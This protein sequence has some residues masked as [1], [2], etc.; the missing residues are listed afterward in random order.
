[1]TNDFPNND[2]LAGQFLAC[3]APG[4]LQLPPEAIECLRQGVARLQAGDPQ[5]AMAPLA[6][7]IQYAPDFSEAHTFLGLANALTSNIYP[8]IDHLE[9]ATQLAPDSFAAQYALAQLHF[10]LRIPQKGYEAAERA[11]SR[12]RTI[13]QRKKLTELLREERTRERNGIARPS[14]NKP[15]SRPTLVLAGTGFLA[16]L[17]AI[18]VHM[19]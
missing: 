13:E 19:H 4:G 12:V 8:A 11:L 9:R 16:I 14:F 6:K 17:I 7:S 18:A 5:A 15:F 2:E 10:K 3:Q 1:M